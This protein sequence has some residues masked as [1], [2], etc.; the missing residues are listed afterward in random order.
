MSVR[1]WH[2]NT[3]GGSNRCSP[4]GGSALWRSELARNCAPLRIQ[5]FAAPRPENCTG[6]S[7]P[8]QRDLRG[9]LHLSEKRAV[10]L[11]CSDRGFVLLFPDKAARVTVHRWVSVVRRRRWSGIAL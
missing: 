11:G 8:R 2:G 4:L 1:W 5:I 7:N 10:A 6:C 9:V 3:G